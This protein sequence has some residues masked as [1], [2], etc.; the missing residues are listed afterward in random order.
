MSLE[1]F[2]NRIAETRQMFRSGERAIRFDPDKRI[3]LKE[4]HTFI[5]QND[6]RFNADKRIDVDESRV[7]DL[8][9]E[10]KFDPDRRLDAKE[11]HNEE[12]ESREK[13]GVDEQKYYTTYNER[14]EHT[15]QKECSYGTWEGERGESKFIP[16]DKEAKA[17]L[18]EYGLDGIE[19]RDAV[20]DFSECSEANVKIDMTQHRQ[21]T[22]DKNT[23]ERITGNFEKA[24][25]RCAE[26]WNETGKDGKTD[27]TARDVSNWRKENQY[28]WH[29]C[30]D[31]ETCN[32]VPSAVHEECKHSG[33]VAE[34]KR[35][36]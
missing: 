18:K 34:F 5:Q 1:S 25:T 19:Y 10:M 22:V 9:N 17:A 29:E 15:P 16:E 32:L 27:W 21:S 8:E 31:M 4:I 23:G 33:G 7:F 14:L 26:R 30:S 11:A 35:R 2:T 13:C 3:D 12:G 24:D 28:T 20:P 6:T 36:D